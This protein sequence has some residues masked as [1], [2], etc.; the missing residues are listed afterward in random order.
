LDSLSRVF[1]D[2]RV[3]WTHRNP[4][5]VVPSFCNLCEMTRRI[6]SDDVDPREIGASTA[7]RLQELVRRGMAFRAKGDERRF[8]DISFAELVRSPLAVVRGVYRFLG[9][10]LNEEA[11][12]RIGAW[13]RINHPGPMRDYRRASPQRYDMGGGHRGA[14]AEYTR[15]SAYLS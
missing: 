8:L 5:Q 7:T 15:R 4:V 6:R 14:H 3:L 12:S 10:T 11:E 9:Q 1:P 2:A 13:L